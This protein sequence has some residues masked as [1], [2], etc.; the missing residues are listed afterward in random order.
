MSE[1]TF[2]PDFNT[3][4]M[5]FLPNFFLSYRYLIVIRNVL[6]VDMLVAGK[7]SMGQKVLCE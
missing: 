2:F 3:I 1:I 7:R 5:I 4:D 6:S